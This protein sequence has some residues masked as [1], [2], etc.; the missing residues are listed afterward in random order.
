MASIHIDENGGRFDSDNKMGENV[1]R[2]VVGDDGSG[3]LDVRDKFGY[4]RQEMIDIVVGFFRNP[5]F[6][7][8]FTH[9]MAQES[10]DTLP[11]C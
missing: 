4:K 5:C 3:G 8:Y 2:L 11:V 7:H 10:Y 9:Y 6:R 1:I